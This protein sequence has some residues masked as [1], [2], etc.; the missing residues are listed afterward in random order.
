MASQASIDE[1]RQAIINCDTE[2]I[3][4]IHLENPELLLHPDS[5]DLRY[6]LL[7]EAAHYNSGSLSELLNSNFF[8]FVKLGDEINLE[9]FLSCAIY[10]DNQQLTA[11]LLRNGAKFEGLRWNMNGSLLA[12]YTKIFANSRRKEML[13]LLVKNGLKTNVKNERGQS[14]LYYFVDKFIDEYDEDAAEIAEILINS[15]VSF[16]EKDENG[17]STLIRSVFRENTRLITLLIE[18]GALENENILHLILSALGRWSCEDLL[19]LFIS[20]GVDINAK[21]DSGISSLHATCLLN[22]NQFIPILMRKGA[23]INAKDSDG[24]TP[25]CSIRFEEKNGQKCAVLLIKEISKLVFENL[26]VSTCDMEVIQA[27]PEFREHF[28]K[29]MLELEQM[30]KTKFYNFYTYYF[31]LK[32]SKNIKKLAKLMK[33]DEFA[34]ELQLKMPDDYFYYKDDL[35]RIFHEGFILEEKI[36]KVYSRL[37]SVFAQIFPDVVIRNLSDCLTVEDLP[38]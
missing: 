21:D 1:L 32:L 26:P 16:N 38:L 11:F 2:K 34:D 30:K 31:V 19:D 14:L 22:K 33:N 13:S 27:K 6:L 20:K 12:L 18:K 15:G 29:C 28:D 35:F 5:C 37:N 3:R 23:N 7:M 24:L 4:E 25:F 17:I 8:N 36:G 9:D 10:D